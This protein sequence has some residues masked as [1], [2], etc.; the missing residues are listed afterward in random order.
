MNLARIAAVL[1]FSLLLVF[2]VPGHAQERAHRGLAVSLKLTAGI[3]YLKVGDLN[4]HIGS[5][6]EYMS[7]R[8]AFYDGGKMRGIGHTVPDLEGEIRFAL[9]S[10]FSL[11][12]G[13][14]Y[15]SGSDKSVFQTAGVFPLSLVDGSMSLS[16]FVLEPRIRAFPLKLGLCYSLPLASRIEL[17]VNG[18][19]GVYISEASLVQVHEIHSLAEPT[20]PEEPVIS[21]RYEVRGN[22]FGL[23]GGVGL[24][25]R[26]ARGLCLAL[27]CQGRYAKVDKLSGTHVHWNSWNQTQGED[28]GIL[29]V[30]VRDMT[31]EG[32]AA[33]CPA[34]AVSPSPTMKRATL[35]FS[36]LSVTIG[37]RVSLF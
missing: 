29:Y 24:E 18:G 28:E 36:G 37:I 25:Y 31:A 27:D 19:M 16:E 26:L 32:Y 17:I 10:R 15:L 6:D 5:F 33:N 7:D 4:S 21:N 20:I 30:G 9:N 14:G 11:A 13:C 12:L 8:L 35:D 2:N 34:L 1:V 22:G 23:H 3:G